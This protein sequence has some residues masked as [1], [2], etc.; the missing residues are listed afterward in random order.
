MR[1]EV[2][3]VGSAGWLL[4]ATHLGALMTI[5]S[6]GTDRTVLAPV[7]AALA[8]GVVALASIAARVRP[9][10]RSWW[11]WA[12]AAGVEALLLVWFRLAEAG[13]ATV[14][15]YSFPVAVLLAATAWAAGRVRPGGATTAPSWALEGPALAMALGPTTLLALGDPGVVRPTVGLAAGAVLL[16]LGAML[17]RRAPIDVGAAAVV[18]LG[19]QALLP[20]A[21]D[22][23][24]WISLGTVGAVLVLLGATFE[25]RR[26]DLHEAKRRYSSL[27]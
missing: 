5:G 2:A 4:L 16:G 6:V 21:D 15:A 18:V 14:E 26:R 24:R 20:Y 27:R 3:A 7:T 10:R 8:L 13:V 12:V 25:E 17:R 22:I 23:P 11:L 9:T 19:L 1:P